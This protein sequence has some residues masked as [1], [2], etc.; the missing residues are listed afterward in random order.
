MFNFNFGDSGLAKT[1]ADILNYGINSSPVLGG[2]NSL[3]DYIQKTY[4]QPQGMSDVGGQEFQGQP[5]KP[6][7]YGSVQRAPMSPQS[8]IRPLNN[9]FD[10]GSL[11]QWSP[12]IASDAQQH[13][14]GLPESKG[15]IAGLIHAYTGGILNGQDPQYAQNYQL[16]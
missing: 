12:Y 3:Y 4:G 2:I 16:S 11:P 6:S 5:I 7:P 1:G 13:I 9:T 14:G 10:D 15:K 8:N